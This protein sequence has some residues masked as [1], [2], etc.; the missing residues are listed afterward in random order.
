ME[1]EN[2]LLS[3]LNYERFELV[4][5]FLKNRKPIYYAVRYHQSQSDKEKEQLAEEMRQ[6]GIV[7]GRKKPRQPE[8]VVS[9]RRREEEDEQPVFRAVRDDEI[10]RINKKVIDLNTFDVEDRTANK[11]E[12]KFKLPQGAEKVERVGYEE[13]HIPASQKTVN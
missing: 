10:A 11:Q 5:L 4:S 1:V 3:I 6:E 12:Y 13:V 7:L 2:N 9:G 8:T